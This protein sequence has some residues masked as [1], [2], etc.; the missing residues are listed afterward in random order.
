MTGIILQGFRCLVVVDGDRNMSADA[1]ITQRLYNY[2]YRLII[3]FT[4][5]ILCP[6]LF[7]C[8]GRLLKCL[9]SRSAFATRFSHPFRCFASRFLGFDPGAF[10]CNVAIQSGALHGYTLL[11]LRPPMRPPDFFLAAAFLAAALPFFVYAY[12]LPATFG[13]AF[14][15]D[16]LDFAPLHFQ[17]LRDSLKGLFG[18]RAAFGLFFICPAL[19]AQ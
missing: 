8:L 17:R 9:G 3:A 4:A 15:Y 11:K 14:S 16:R 10:F 13:I 7:R 5:T 18:L 19:L 6:A 2:Q 1:V 12:F